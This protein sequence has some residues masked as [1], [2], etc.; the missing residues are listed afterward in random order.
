MIYFTLY[1]ARCKRGPCPFTC[2]FVRTVDTWQ[3]PMA[4]EVVP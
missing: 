4:D 2:G 3:A 1:H